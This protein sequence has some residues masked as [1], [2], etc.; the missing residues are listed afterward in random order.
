MLVTIYAI[1]AATMAVGLMVFGTLKGIEPWF[2][3]VLAFLVLSQLHA[4]MSHGAER[5][6]VSKGFADLNSF[7]TGLSRD[8]ERSEKE[9]EALKERF[10][11]ESLGQSD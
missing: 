7:I 6:R 5:K 3:G 11:T 2:A 10:E 4:A 1:A 8:L 9:L